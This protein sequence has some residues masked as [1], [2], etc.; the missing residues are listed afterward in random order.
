MPAGS[1]DESARSLE[2]LG[3]LEQDVV[4][5]GEAKRLGSLEIDDKLEFPWL[6]DR[7]IGGFGALED[8]IHVVGSPTIV[9]ETAR[10]IG[11]QGTDLCIGPDLSYDRQSSPHG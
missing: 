10:P 9:G 7:Q 1:V 4:G 2:H 6:L 5:D 8:S 11:K 3:G